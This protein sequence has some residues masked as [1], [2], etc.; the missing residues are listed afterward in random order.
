VNTLATTALL[1]MTFPERLVE[2]RKSR[3]LTQQGL[4]DLAGIHLT[5]IQRY[6]KGEAQPT[7]DMIR[8]LSLALSVSADWLLFDVDERGPDDALKRQFEA[9]R[10]FDDDERHVAEVVLE[11]LILKH[12]AKQ[13][14]LRTQPAPKRTPAPTKPAPTRR[15][16]QR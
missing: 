4:A 15:A 14:V 1:A 8:K 11:S 12:Q 5:Q 10:Q 6:E 9:L 16:S 7:L 2:I 13:A 3:T